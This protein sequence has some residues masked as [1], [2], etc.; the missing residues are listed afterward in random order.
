MT[1]EKLPIKNYGL[2]LAKEK[3]E[4]Q[5]EDWIGGGEVFV[6]EL[7]IKGNRKKY[8]PIGEIQQAKEDMMDCASRSPAN[9]AETK[10]T[11]GVQ[12]KVLS[13]KTIDW[14]DRRQ[15]LNE[16]GQVMIAD[17]NIAIN[18]GTTRRGN[19]LKAP[20]HAIHKIGIAPKKLL[21]LEPWMY[22]KDYH[23]PKRLTKE[24]KDIEKESLEIFDFDYE[25]ILFATFDNIIDKDVLSV[26][27]FAW[28]MPSNGE[29]PRINLSANHAFM[30]FEKPRYEIFDNYVDSFD[31][32]FIKNLASNYLLLSYGYRLI[33]TEKNSNQININE[34]LMTLKENC[35]YQLVDPPGGAG[36]AINGKLMIGDPGAVAFHFLMRNKGDIAGKT[37]CVKKKLWDSFIP[38]GSLD[39]L[40]VV[41]DKLVKSYSKKYLQKKIKTHG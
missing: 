18:S 37:I 3:R 9:I 14:F 35:M 40:G 26:A 2:N 41:D 6:N 13:Q 38:F 1:K 30:Y 11:Y 20:I 16:D 25:Q 4:Q 19:S 29:Y 27:G 17:A 21:P 8:L 28:G 33:I 31:G 12:T 34:K 39:T 32:D 36:L 7:L 23:N 22:W 15:F 10:L 5:P 24:I